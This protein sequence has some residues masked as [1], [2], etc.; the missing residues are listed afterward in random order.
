M[1][2]PAKPVGFLVF[3]VP[4][5]PAVAVDLAFWPTATIAL[6]LA[7]LEVWHTLKVKPIVI[8]IVVVVVAVVGEVRLYW[9]RPISLCLACSIA[10]SRRV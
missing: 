3:A 9:H 6:N 1:A 10:D 2:V 7:P 4:D 5:G 8:L